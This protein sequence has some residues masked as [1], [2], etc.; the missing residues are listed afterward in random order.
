MIVLM[1]ARTIRKYWLGEMNR[2][3]KR[4]YEGNGDANDH[5]NSSTR[6]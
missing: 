3:T 4:E 1:W 5:D 6:E 2:E